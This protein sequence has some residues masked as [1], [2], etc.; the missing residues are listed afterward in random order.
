MTFHF[1]NTKSAMKKFTFILLLF[2]IGLNLTGQ[3]TL[4]VNISY[5]MNKTNPPSY[6]FST[7]FKGEAGKCIW[8]FGN[9]GSSELA[10]PTYTFKYTN[11]YPVIVKIIDKTN[12]VYYGKLEARFEG[13]TVLSTPCK[14][15]FSASVV[16]TSNSTLAGSK[17]ISFKNL[18]TGTIKECIWYFGDETKSAEL[19]P[20]H[21]YA[22]FGEYKVTLTILTTDD[23]KSEYSTVV[24]VAD[25]AVSVILYAKGKVKDLSALASCKWGIVAEDGTFLLPSEMAMDFVFKEGQYVE[26]AYQYLPGSNTA[27]QAGRPVKI[28]KIAEIVIT[29]VCKALFT[30]TINPANTAT[31]VASKKV[32]FVN[33]STGTIKEC[34]WTFGDETKSAELNPVHEYKA[35][36]EYKVCLTI[37]T[38]DG[39]RSEYCTAIK[40]TD[41]VI[42]VIIYAKGYVKELSAAATDCKWGIVVDNVTIL[43]PVVMVQ[44]FTFKPGQN[45]EF[46]YELLQNITT[47]CSMGKP[48]KIHKIAEIPVVSACKAYFTATNDLWSN[49]AMMKKMVFANNSTGDIKE[50]KW[51]FGDGTTGSEL[52]P[53]HE[54][55]KYGEYKV[56]LNIVTTTGCQSEFCA[57]VVVD[58]LKIPEACSFDL[59]I[60]PKDVAKNTFLFYAISNSEI[61]AWKW[62][63]GDGKSSDAQNP[64]HAYEKSGIYEVTCTIITSTGCTAAK[65]LKLT[66]AEPAL[67]LCPGAISLVLFDP[68][69]DV[70]VCT[71]K[72][73][74]TLLNTD[75][76]EYESVKY[77]WSNGQTGNTATNLCANRQYYVNAVVDSKCQKN[78]SFAFLTSPAWKYEY[79]NGK[80]SFTVLAPSDSLIYRWDFGDGNYAFGKSVEYNY[81][82]EGNY[83]VT[84][85]AISGSYSNDSS[86]KVEVMT[87][88]T[89]VKE[90]G[91][92]DLTIF[93]NPVSDKLWIDFKKPVTGT[94]TTEIIDMKGQVVS[95]I[96]YM[97]NSQNLIPVQTSQL[98]DGIYFLRINCDKQFING[99]KFFKHK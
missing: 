84:L 18:S 93:P 81:A 77:T 7:D 19:N 76:K 91:M 20:V 6:T 99:I 62:S 42:P 65:A 54:Y 85:S 4:T 78:T 71:G 31:D 83:D 74:A 51:S 8:Y 34:V 59:I 89:P 26:F 46:A 21:E 32:A 67:P 47:T 33:K 72:A 17:K 12:A 36:G 70:K 35:L 98:Q 3:N 95:A 16:P 48:V 9:E 25:P 94:V 5:V 45:V 49:P 66:V 87:N 61:K 68:S 28:L 11:T 57:V 40:L 44:N 24:K 86:Q 43:I 10:S 15:L 69:P 14:A 23:C 92:N 29:P 73:I 64:E 38:T 27:C 1:N 88:I 55:P 60:K 37:V 30:F 82:K 22:A 90:L 80:V 39:C 75:G 58:S 53:I 56:C 50:C 63:F 96:Q 41:P 79:A 13:T 52:S 2:F 97:L